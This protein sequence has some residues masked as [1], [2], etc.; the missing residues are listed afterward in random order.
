MESWISKGVFFMGLLSLYI[1][2]HPGKQVT[3]P[4]IPSKAL[5]K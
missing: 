5:A 1:Q 3:V 4:N 2:K